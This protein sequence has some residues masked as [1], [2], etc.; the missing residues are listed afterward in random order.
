MHNHFLIKPI[1]CNQSS[2]KVPR[3]CFHKRNGWG[4]KEV[5]FQYQLNEDKN[6]SINIPE[7]GLSELRRLRL[8]A[9]KLALHQLL[10]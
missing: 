8:L 4:H 5:F 3:H 7:L 1:H 10:V 9:E 6:N 2:G